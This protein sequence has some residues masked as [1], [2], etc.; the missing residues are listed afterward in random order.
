MLTRITH[1]VT[2]VASGPAGYDG[3]RLTL[4]LERLADE[5]RDDPRVAEATLQ[6]VR[7]GDRT[8]IV[9][10]LD[11][12]DARYSEEGPTYPGIDGPPE[13]AGAGRTHVLEGFQIVM[14]GLLPT[15][16]GGLM[17]AHPACIDFWGRGAELSPFSDAV[18]LAV[19]LELVEGLDDKGAADDAIRRG[20]LTLSRAIGQLAAEAPGSATSYP[21][22]HERPADGDL[23]A[24]AYVYQI[25]S[26]G[27]PL[28]T[29]LYGDDL[30]DLYPTL[31]DPVEVLDGAMVTGNHGLQ[32]V[33]T[34]SH[35]NNPV[36]LRLMAEDG[37]SLRLLPIVLMEGHQKASVLKQRSANQAVQLLRHL[38]AEAAVLTQEG[39]GMSVVDQMLTIEGAEAAGI[40]CVA[41]TYEM[42][43]E[44]G[45]DTPLIHFSR[46]A[47]HLVSTGNREERVQ[48][49]APDRVFGR[50]ADGTDFGDLA[51]EV[52][53]PLYGLFGSTSQVGQT[54]VQGYAA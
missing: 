41:I 42:A 52:R 19:D 9:S 3:T 25:Q 43:G 16:D 18:T 20:G 37:T 40:R 23:P 33:P 34:I 30:D 46:S 48:L 50:G 4:D 13:V 49:P 38:G 28:Q 22:V 27:P 39:G 31:I 51:G 1:P 54:T 10:V 53:I 29:F 11:V 2:E 44:E 7:P 24:V 5:V 32:T 17:V 8:R 15:G 47:R 12:M 6:I 35:V 26:Q 45:T 36:L 14:S 21:A